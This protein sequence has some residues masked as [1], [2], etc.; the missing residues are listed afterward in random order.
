MIDFI[1]DCHKS[2]RYLEIWDCVSKIYIIKYQDNVSLD[3]LYKKN[4]EGCVI[5]IK[6]GTIWDENDL[7]P[8]NA[9]IDYNKHMDDAIWFV[10]NCLFK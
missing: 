6:E 4:Y 7:D 2:T 5:D 8:L 10:E 9:P 1:K 3:Q